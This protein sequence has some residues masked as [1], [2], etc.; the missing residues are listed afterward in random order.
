MNELYGLVYELDHLDENVPVLVRMRQKRPFIPIFVRH[1]SIL[2]KSLYCRS[3][4]ALAIQEI[5]AR[6]Q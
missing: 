3:R 5:S 2:V 1:F 4:L 6:I